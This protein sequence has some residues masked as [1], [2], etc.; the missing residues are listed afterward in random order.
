MRKLCATL[1]IVL[2]IPPVLAQEKIVFSSANPFTFRDIILHLA[3]QESQDVFGTLTLPKTGAE[4]EKFPLIIALA[5]SKGWATHH[6]EYIQMYHEMGIA[7]FEIKSFESRG[8][9]STVGSQVSVTTAMMVLDSYKALEFLSNHPNINSSKVA[10]TGWSLG[11]GVALYAGWEPLRKAINPEYSFIAHLSFYPPC[12]VE[13]INLNFTSAPIRIL[14]GEFDDWTP[15]D[16]C[17]DLV[18]KLQS[19]GADI[20]V[21]VYPGSHHS[22][23]RDSDPVID[24]K[25]YVLTNCRYKMNDDGTILTNRLNFPMRTPLFQKISLAFC[26]TRGPTYGGNPAARL[27]SFQFSKEFM[28][29]HLLESSF[30]K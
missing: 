17:V 19:S 2:I 13:P 24:P 6:A 22:F 8:V 18:S 7:T 11:G 1:L 10:I 5:G 12:I 26:A 16:Q 4:D 14:I 25:G 23:D 15:A 9:T 30:P 27:A 20:H 3:K 28:N 29:D 21:T